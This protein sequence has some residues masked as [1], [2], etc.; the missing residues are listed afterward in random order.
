MEGN[1]VVPDKEIKSLVDEQINGKYFYI[2]P[3][4]NI[5]FYP[6]NNIK[7]K[8]LKTF[9]RVYYVKINIA[10][11]TSIVVTVKERKPYALWCGESIPN[12]NITSKGKCY[13]ID[14]KGFL[15]AKSP[16]FSDNVYFTVYGDVTGAKSGDLLGGVF[17]N[18]ER[19]KKFIRLKDLLEKEGI[20]TSKL[21]QK[22]NNDFE[23]YISPSG[24]LIFNESQ[25][26]KKLL[27]NLVSAID[28]KKSEGKDINKNLEYIDARFNNKVIFKFTP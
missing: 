11:L 28:V 18:E 19:L 1:D 21:V 23:F 4:N 7:N 3:K 27:R 26:M 24:V 8:I 5:F 16:T 10:D 14:D 17:L 9:K 25:D 20:K 2:I 15:F 22:E 6:K 13:F 12:D